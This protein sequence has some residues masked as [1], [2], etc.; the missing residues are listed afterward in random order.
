MLAY[1]S[2]IGIETMLE[3]F[4]HDSS[5]ADVLSSL[6]FSIMLTDEDGKALLVSRNAKK[7]FG[8]DYFKLANKYLNQATGG[9]LGYM[10]GR[11]LKSKIG[12]VESEE[13]EI[14]VNELEMWISY[15]V[16]RTK[17]K[18]KRGKAIFFHTIQDIT[19][20][21]NTELELQES[22]EK[23]MKLTQAGISAVGKIV[24]SRDPYTSNHQIMVG[25]V[26]Y[27]IAK[28]MGFTEER[29][30]LIKSAG[31]L[32]DVGKISIPVQILS[33]PSKLNDFEYQV[34]KNHVEAGYNILKD[35]N[36]ALPVSDMIMEHHER[37]DGSGYPRGLKEDE[38]SREG[39]ILAV[40]DVVEAMLS[41][42]PYRPKKTMEDLKK[43]LTE[44]AGVLYEEDAAYTAIALLDG[45]AIRSEDFNLQ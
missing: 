7:Y 43:E 41:H 3:I 25:E 12:K 21:K 23:M 37:L 27:K 28:A 15:T 14:F 19:E 45:N 8:Q 32:H 38:I 9:M 39:K 5:F 35:V 17:L 30:E 6:P 1:D 11:G 40:A 2:Y 16:T 22:L 18:T 26:A 33:K 20:R 31:V 24:E 42:R 29:A 36:F 10:K 4:K 44:N 13:H 34:V